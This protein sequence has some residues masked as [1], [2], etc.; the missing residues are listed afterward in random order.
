M[1]TKEELE[2]ALAKAERKVEKLEARVA[3]LE[4][5]APA[6]VTDAAPVFGPGAIPL[7][8]R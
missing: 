1:P 2:K 4:S 8:A 3:E 7:E 5:A 6:P